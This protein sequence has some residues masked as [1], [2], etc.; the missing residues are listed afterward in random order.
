MKSGQAQPARDPA[1]GHEQGDVGE[2]PGRCADLTPLPWRLKVPE[3][4]RIVNCQYVKY[5]NSISGY[6]GSYCSIICITDYLNT[7]KCLM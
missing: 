3:S 5:C 1:L 4:L 6:K 2:G 7:S